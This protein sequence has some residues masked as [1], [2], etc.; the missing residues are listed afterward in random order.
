MRSLSRSL[1]GQLRAPL[2][3]FQLGSPL[4]HQR[5]GGGGTRK[6]AGP[7]GATS[8]AGW[9]C[10]NRRAADS[11]SWGGLE[12]ERSAACRAGRPR[13]CF[14]MGQKVGAAARVAGSWRRASGRPFARRFTCAP[15]EICIQLK[16]PKQS[17]GGNQ[18]HSAV[19]NERAHAHKLVGEHINSAE[20][21]LQM[22][23]GPN[24]DGQL[25]LANRPTGASH[26]TGQA[27]G[28]R[29]Q[30]GATL[31]GRP[32]NGLGRL[33]QSNLVLVLVLFFS[34]ALERARPLDLTAGCLHVL[35]AAAAAAQRVP[36]SCQ[37]ARA[38]RVCV[39]ESL[40]LSASTI[41]ATIS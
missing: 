8:V 24:F 30:T 7:P 25:Q 1:V 16:A 12:C 9:R 28:E 35:V 21:S 31:W 39:S 29:A 13:H 23:F 17:G 20:R 26:S 19:R 2:A 22:D 10:A 34:A 38:R 15:I 18:L 4:R 27:S 5:Q 32:C 40:A 41:G 11:A 3:R 36:N 37:S 33:Q 6:A 14:G